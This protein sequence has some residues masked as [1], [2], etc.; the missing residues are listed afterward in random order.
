MKIPFCDVARLNNSI[1]EE[2]NFAM[3]KVM[4]RGVFILGDEVLLFERRWAEYVGTHHCITCGNGTDALELVL[5]AY[6][7][8]AGDE[9]IVPAFGW[10]SPALAVKRVGARPVFVDVEGPTGNIDVDKV[11]EALTNRTRAV[12]PIH[13]FGNPC[14]IEDLRS[15]CVENALLL[16]E[17]CAQAHGAQVGGK[18]VGAFGNA[19][20]FSFYPTKNLSCLGDGGAIMTSDDD[21]AMKLMAKRNYGRSEGVNFHYSGRNSRMDEL[22]AAILNVK[23]NYLEAWNEERRKI[24]RIYWQALDMDMKRFPEYS[25]WY[26]F[27]LRVFERSMVIRKFNAHHIGTQIHAKY[28]LNSPSDSLPMERKWLNEGFSIPI[29]QGLS[30]SEIDY[31]TEKLKNLPFD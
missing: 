3:E 14:R 29:H 1:K 5:E 23:L 7:I 26:Q 4:K 9:V 13:L 31:V 17:D 6:G 12:I 24:A 19:S 10:M 27:P 22:Q 25:V 8:G 11:S 2:L 15:I 30:A 28:E 18:R 16:I 20:I 21:L